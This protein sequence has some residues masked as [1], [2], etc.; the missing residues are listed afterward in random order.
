M[1][2]QAVFE[3]KLSLPSPLKGLFEVF[4][5][6]DVANTLGQSRR[7]ARLGKKL[8]D[9]IVI[10][11]LKRHVESGLAREHKPAGRRVALAHFRQ[12]DCARHAWHILI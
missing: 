9:R 1:R 8:S 11:R 7:V 5:S 6:E 12:K 2:E 10:D 3:F 4:F